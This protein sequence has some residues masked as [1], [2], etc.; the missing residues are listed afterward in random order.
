MGNIYVLDTHAL[1]WF[2]EGRDRLGDRARAAIEETDVLLIVPL[3]V[4][5]EISQMI[6]RRRTSI[7]SVDEFLDIVFSAPAMHLAP[8]DFLTLARSFDLTDIPELHDRLIA[9]TAVRSAEIFGQA[10]PLITR[11]RE[12]VAAGIVPVV[13]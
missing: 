1:V 2:L 12:I 3:I 4:L 13:W 6:R 11:D 7:P 10:V 5:A 8:L 9:A